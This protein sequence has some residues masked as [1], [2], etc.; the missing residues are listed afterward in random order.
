VSAADVS[1]LLITASRLKANTTC[2]LVSSSDSQV[3]VSRIIST[4]RIK[5]QGIY[6]AVTQNPFIV[7]SS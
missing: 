1:G 4:R 7:S 5:E 3:K 6:T 2:L